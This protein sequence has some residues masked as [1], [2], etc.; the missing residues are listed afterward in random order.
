TAGE[1]LND[2]G[3][4]D[5][6]NNSLAPT[7]SLTITGAGNTI[8]VINAALHDRV[9][10]VLGSA[11]LTLQNLALVNGSV[12]GDGGC[13]RS[14]GP[15]LTLTS[16]I[17]QS[18]VASAN[19]GGVASNGVTAISASII[20]SN[21]AGPNVGDSGGGLSVSGSGGL[22]IA[23]STIDNNTAGDSGGGMISNTIGAVLIT[24]STISR[25]QLSN[26]PGTAGGG[27]AIFGASLNV[28]IINSTISGNTAGGAGFGG[29]IDTVTP[30]T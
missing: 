13:I 25:N 2:Q 12:T 20:R 26:S 3:D 4:F 23:N 1:D 6:F 16:V 27:G 29:G 28:T 30:L 15:A 14:A 9:F 22:T 7:Y 5:V 11:S 19:G 8:T 21:H 10:D 17:V 24:G 18:C